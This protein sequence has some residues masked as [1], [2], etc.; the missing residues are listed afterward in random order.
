[1]A[2]KKEQKKAEEMLQK[3]LSGET[4]AIFHSTNGVSASKQ[5]SNSYRRKLFT[6]VD[7]RIV[8]VTLYVSNLC[9]IRMDSFGNLITRYTPQEIVTMIERNIARAIRSNSL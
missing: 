5:S 6:I 1:M 8:D 2:D 3:Y 9:G 7:G 4:P